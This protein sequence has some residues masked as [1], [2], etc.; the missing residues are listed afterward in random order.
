V[1]KCQCLGRHIPL[2]SWA[3]SINRIIPS[4]ASDQPDHQEGLSDV[5]FRMAVV[6]VPS[7][8]LVRSELCMTFRTLAAS[9]LKYGDFP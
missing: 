5:A 6:A 4:A 1:R 3:A 7:P 9:L 2:Q 8:L